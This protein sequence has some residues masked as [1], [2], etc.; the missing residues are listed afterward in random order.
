VR[1]NFIDKARDERYNMGT[2]AKPLHEKLV[3]VPAHRDNNA[4]PTISY[5]VIVDT[6]GFE[7]E[8]R[9]NSPRHLLEIKTPA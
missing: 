7:L 4:T 1:G 3:I 9:A 8:W 5:C 2:R 6:F